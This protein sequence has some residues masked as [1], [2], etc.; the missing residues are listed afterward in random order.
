MVRTGE[1]EGVCPGL[2]NPSPFTKAKCI[3]KPAHPAYS[4]KLLCCNHAW[5][6]PTL[7]APPLGSSLL[8][9]LNPLDI[10]TH[11]ESYL[12]LNKLA[13]AFFLCSL[14]ASQKGHPV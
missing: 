9:D 3:L 1:T 8:L 10:S 11:C 13:V 6:P 14:A 4:S 5:V 12:Q 2:R 7:P